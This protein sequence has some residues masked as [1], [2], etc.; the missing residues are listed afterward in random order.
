MVRKN[1]RFIFNRITFL[2][3]FLQLSPLSSEEQTLPL[4]D[5]LYDP[6]LEELERGI[7][8]RPSKSWGYEARKEKRAKILA[9]GLLMNSSLFYNNTSIILLY[10]LQ[11]EAIQPM[12]NLLAD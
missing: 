6:T 10:Y 8:I 12:D 7:L 11:A 3:F 1:L 2:F 9:I 5:T 4:W